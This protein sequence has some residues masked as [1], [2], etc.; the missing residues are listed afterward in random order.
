MLYEVCMRNKSWFARARYLGEFTIENGALRL[1]Y[2][3]G[4]NF[5]PVNIK[6]G[7]YIRIINSALN[8]GVYLW[9]CSTLED[10]VFDGGVW[11]MSPPKAFID[12]VNAVA[13]DIAKNK[14]VIFSPYSS[15]SF[16]GYSYNK[17]TNGGCSGG[18]SDW[19]SIYGGRFS[20]WRKAYESFR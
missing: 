4:Q 3:D 15:E 10:E 6:A 13:D 2:D 9:P 19:W 16:G 11:V 17:Q 1:T 8:D 20:Q 7:Q 14:D 18:G 12:E 5:C